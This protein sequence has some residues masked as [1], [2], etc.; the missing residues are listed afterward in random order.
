MLS[1]PMGALDVALGDISS[2]IA[3][4]IGEIRSP[5][6]PNLT[7]DPTWNP[8]EGDYLKSAHPGYDLGTFGIDP[9]LMMFTGIPGDMLAAGDP[10]SESPF[11]T[12]YEEDPELKLYDPNKL[13]PW[14]I[15]TSGKTRG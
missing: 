6:D 13:M 7:A 12:P 3:A 8:F 2:N 4:A 5:S 11:Y 14:E 10:E 9:T 1:A 15:D